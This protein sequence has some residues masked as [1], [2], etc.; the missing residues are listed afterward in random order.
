MGDGKAELAEGVFF[1]L[2]GWVQCRN[3][4]VEQLRL[5]L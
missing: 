2:L 1:I 3:G 4:G 5:G